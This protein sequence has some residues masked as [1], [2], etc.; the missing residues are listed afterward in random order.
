MTTPI[1]FRGGRLPERPEQ[2]KLRLGPLLH[3]RLPDPPASADWLSPVPEAAW[4]MLGNDQYG[5][6]TC[7]GVGHMRIGDVFVNQGAT[8]T[9][10]TAQALAFY[11]AITGFRPDDPSTDQGA[12]CQDV[13]DYWRKNGFLGEKIV[14]FARVNVKSAKEVRQAIQI[15]GQLYT[16]FQVPDSAMEQFNAGQPWDVVE[17]ASIEGGHC[18]TVG[19]YDKDGLTAVTWGKTQRLTWDFWDAYFEE[20]WVVVGPDDINPSSGL[21]ARGL[22]LGA[23]QADFTALTGKKLGAS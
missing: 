6:C 17:G 21:D 5:D 20:A 2:P 23:L 15:F 10:T 8:L 19:A 3:P 16:G 11:S 7:A 4:G 1:S 14:A 18:V 12:V 9:V 22:N 13:L